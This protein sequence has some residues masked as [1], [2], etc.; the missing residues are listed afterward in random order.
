[1]LTTI[2]PMALLAVLSID[3]ALKRQNVLLPFLV[4]P[5]AG[6]HHIAQTQAN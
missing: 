5:K 6:L 4:S 1:M 3:R 2:A